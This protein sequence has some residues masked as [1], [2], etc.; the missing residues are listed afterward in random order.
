MQPATQ[1]VTVFIADDH[2]LVIEGIKTLLDVPEIRVVGQA[3]NGAHLEQCLIVDQVPVDVL[4]LDLNMPAFAPGAFGDKLKFDPVAFVEKLKATRPDVRILAL[5][6]VPDPYTINAMVQ[7]G[8]DGCT[9]KTASSQL[10]EPILLVAQGHHY[11]SSE[12]Q[13]LLGNFQHRDHSVVER[14]SQLSERDFQV[15]LLLAQGHS[16]DE[17]AQQLGVRRVTA[18]NYISLLYST[19]GVENRVQATAWAL[20]NGILG[21]DDIKG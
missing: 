8:L 1:P 13:K 9:L 18:N 12:T 19:I 4:L 20:K 17:I 3:S 21:L 6:G 2:D 14:P 15:L 10:L 7:H 11:I 16:N 5:T